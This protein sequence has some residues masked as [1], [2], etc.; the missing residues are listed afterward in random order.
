MI[1]FNAGE[2]HFTAE[3]PRSPRKA[4]GLVEYGGRPFFSGRRRARRAGVPAPHVWRGHC[5]ERILVSG[6]SGPIGTAL[7]SSFQPALE[8]RGMQ[9]VRLVRALAQSAAEVSSNPLA[10]LS[11][12]TVSV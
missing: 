11:P 10:A 2:S 8:P 4:F 6:A 7:L 5:L 12:P 3:S 1:D 9:I